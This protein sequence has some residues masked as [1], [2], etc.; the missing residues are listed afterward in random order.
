MVSSFEISD[1]PSTRQGVVCEMRWRE[2]GARAVATAYTHKANISGVKMWADNARVIATDHDHW[3]SSKVQNCD[4]LRTIN[5]ELS[6]SHQQTVISS[7]DIMPTN[8][9]E[10]AVELALTDNII[11]GSCNEHVPTHVKQTKYYHPS[12]N[13]RLSRSET[14]SSIHGKRDREPSRIFVKKIVSLMAKNKS[15]RRKIKMFIKKMIPKSSAWHNFLSTAYCKIFLH[16]QTNEWRFWK[17]PCPCCRSHKH[18][19]RGIITKNK[20][21]FQSNRTKILNTSKG[22]IRTR[23]IFDQCSLYIC[24]DIE[25]NPGPA[26]PISLLSARLAQIGRIPVNITGDGNCFFRSVSHQ[27]YHTETH[28]AQIRALAIQHL[29]NCPEH[30]IESST[31]QSWVQYLQNMSRLGTWADHIIIQAVANSQN[32]RINITESASNFNQTTIVNSIYH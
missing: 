27:L 10:R 2:D 18:S 13:L 14:E 7:G 31:D 16:R 22:N 21:N 12:D 30:F 11:S 24:G 5:N 8:L 23:K 15:R 26:N 17:L 6:R 29:I 28:H 32:L 9:C 4:L 1:N 20:N 3:S 19:H 25:L